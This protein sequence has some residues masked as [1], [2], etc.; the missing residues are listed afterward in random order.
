MFKH[1]TA[2]AKSANVIQRIRPTS[3]T[4]LDMRHIV[5]PWIAGEPGLPI[6]K[7]AALLALALVTLPTITPQF[8]QVAPGPTFDS[9]LA[10][11]NHAK[12]ISFS[13]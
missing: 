12:I 3:P 5:S 4:A 1:V 2:M 10:N 13:A 11:L 7:V 6:S 8:Q 9:Q